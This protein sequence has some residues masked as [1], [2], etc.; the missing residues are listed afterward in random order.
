MIGAAAQ[1]IDAFRS[2]NLKLALAESLTGGALASALVDVPGASEVLL[3]SVVAYDSKLK[4]NLLNVP[5]GLIETVGAVDPLVALGMASGVRF[6]LAQAA[7]LDAVQVVGFGITG[8]AGP[9]EQDNHPVGEVFAA[10][11][12]A[13]GARQHAWMFTGSRNEIREA[14]VSKGLKLLLEVIG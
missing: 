3:G 13:Q 11:V 5:S 9:T 1:V 10:V 12:T 2:A 6:Q 8:V 4:T 14:A 7:E